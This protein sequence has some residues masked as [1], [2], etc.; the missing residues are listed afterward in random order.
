M[1]DFK[2]KIKNEG[3][4]VQRE[5]RQRVAGYILTA[6]GLVAGLAWNDAI[7]RIIDYFA[8]NKGNNILAQLIYA[9]I[10]TFIVVIAS[11][12]AMKLLNSKRERK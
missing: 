4:E 10:A 2:E 3:K 5:V 6:L 12:C 7:K 8:P 11:I 9:I 1:E